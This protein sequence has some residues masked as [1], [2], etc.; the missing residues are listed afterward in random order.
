MTNK[1]LSTAPDF[2]RD[3]IADIRFSRRKLA[4]PDSKLF[5]TTKDWEAEVSYHDECIAKVRR[6]FK[7]RHSVKP[8]RYGYFI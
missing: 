2:V 7:Q 3:L 5:N 4:L 8:N 1:S 6:L